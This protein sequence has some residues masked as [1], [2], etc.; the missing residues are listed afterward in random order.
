[1]QKFE[2]PVALKANGRSN[3]WIEVGEVEECWIQNFSKFAVTET[4]FL[5]LRFSHHYPRRIQK[6]NIN[7][8]ITNLSS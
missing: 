4:I 3:F 1:M 7:H 2:R 6:S 8:H 5:E